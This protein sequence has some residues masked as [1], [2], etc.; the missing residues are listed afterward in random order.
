MTRKLRGSVGEGH[1]TR[2]VAYI[3]AASLPLAAASGCGLFGN[4]QPEM[5]QVTFACIT[6]DGTVVD[7]DNCDDD[8]DG[9]GGSFFIFSGSGHHNYPPGS[10]VPSGGQ[11]VAYNDG[12]GRERLGLPP[13]GA[14]R[15]GPGSVSRGGFGS[16]GGGKSGTGGG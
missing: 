7:Q 8:G 1:L 15:V 6:P 4:D 5:E 16:G 12:P 2:R 10:K 14:P 3:F 13:K 11:R 9:H